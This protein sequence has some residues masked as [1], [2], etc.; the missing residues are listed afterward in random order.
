MSERIRRDE[1]LGSGDDI[2]KVPEP[3]KRSRLAGWLSA[4]VPKEEK[5]FDLFEQQAAKVVAGAHLLRD[6]VESYV[7]V[8]SKAAR[9]KEVE[10]DG[11]LIIHEIMDKLNRSFITPIERD[12]IRALAQFLD[13][14]LDDVEGVGARLVM[15]G[16]KKPTAACQELVRI[17]CRAAEEIEKA[18]KNLKD[19]QNLGVFLV[20]VSRLEN[21]ADHITREQIGKLFREEQDLR[22]LIR[23]KE[24]Y[25]RLENCADRCEDVGNIIEDIVVKNA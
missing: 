11:D 22:E 25:Q 16:V 6:L 17:I 20:E 14:V 7:D 2:P 12:D 23:W 18:V 1:V 9:L 19:L 15:F 10:H 4:L 24:I 5:F 3:R 8:E 13:D 21:Q